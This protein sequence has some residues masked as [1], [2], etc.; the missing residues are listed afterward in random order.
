MT[1]KHYKAFASIINEQL[2]EIQEVDK[3]VFPKSSGEQ[4]LI[5][6]AK[7]MA[8]VFKQDNARFNPARFFTACGFPG[9][10]G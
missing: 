1:R 10:N 8:V 7:D 3:L 5:T 6:L 2:K 9:Y 4:M